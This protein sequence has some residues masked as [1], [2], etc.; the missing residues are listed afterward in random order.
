[1]KSFFDELKKD[2]DGFIDKDKIYW[3][4]KNDY[5]YV[6]K[7]AFCGCGNPEEVSI[8]YILPI[9]IK[10]KDQYNFDYD[11]LQDMFVLYYLTDKNFIEHGSTVRCSWLTENGKILLNDLMQIKKECKEEED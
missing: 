3:E 10:I 9:L 8:N 2:E 5:I 4:E 1:M 11:N 7:L 6:E